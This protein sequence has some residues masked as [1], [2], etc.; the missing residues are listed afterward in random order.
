MTSGHALKK[1]FLRNNLNTTGDSEN[2]SAYAASNVDGSIVS[3]ARSKISKVTSKM[4][5]RKAFSKTSGHV[6][7][8]GKSAYKPN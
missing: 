7:N 4:S 2:G 5:S 8:R 3:G 6:F 1:R